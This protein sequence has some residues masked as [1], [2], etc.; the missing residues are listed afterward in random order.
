[1]QR[2]QGTEEDQDGEAEASVKEEAGEAERLL[3]EWGRLNAAIQA[4]CKALLAAQPNAATAVGPPSSSA[5]G[6][7]RGAR[8]PKRRAAI[9]LQTRGERFGRGLEVLL[10]RL[11]RQA[12][13]DRQRLA[14][15]ER[16]NEDLLAR[17]VRLR[18]SVPAPLRRAHLY[19]RST[20]LVFSAY[21]I[22]KL[23]HVARSG[24]NVVSAGHDPQDGA[25]A[26]AAEAEP[27]VLENPIKGRGVEKSRYRKKI[28]HVVVNM[29]ATRPRGGPAAAP[30]P[31]PP[32]TPTGTEEDEPTGEDDRVFC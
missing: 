16:E 18:Q 4:G 28:K 32:P 11:E 20:P 17:V 19:C 24:S 26:A 30:S 14:G 31:L 1:M 29:S 27:E 10:R 8:N 5:T 9:N 23:R 3:E 7:T 2:D 22:N 15:L 13:E 6:G 21:S 12:A 25:A